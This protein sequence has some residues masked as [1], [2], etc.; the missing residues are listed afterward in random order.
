MR[1]VVPFT[2]DEGAS[3]VGDPA[4]YADRSADDRPRS[5]RTRAEPSASSFS[6]D[7]PAPASHAATPRRP[8]SRRRRR[9]AVSVI[10][11]LK[12]E[13]DAVA[14]SWIALASSGGN[15]TDRLSR[16]AM[17]QVVAQ[18]VGQGAGFESSACRKA[19]S[20]DARG[21]DGEADR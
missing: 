14:A 5:S 9:E 3:V 17:P 21:L 18:A 4:T 7:G 1:R 20:D 10:H 6:V 19:C 16:C 13:P 11:A 15:D 2:S 12:V 8:A